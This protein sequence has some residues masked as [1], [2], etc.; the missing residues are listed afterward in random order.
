MSALTPQEKAEIDIH[1]CE[2]K[3]LSDFQRDAKAVFI[4]I[5]IYHNT[6]IVLV[7]AWLLQNNTIATS[8][9]DKG[10]L[11]PLVYVL[12]MMNSMLIIAGFYQLYSFN[13]VAVHFRVLRERLKALVG[14]DVL[15]YEDKFLYTKVLAPYFAPNLE[16]P[17]I[18][19]WCLVPFLASTIIFFKGAELFRVGLPYDWWFRDLSALS[20]LLPIPYVAVILVVLRIT[21]VIRNANSPGKK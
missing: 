14:K 20:S 17:P 4:R 8:L 11:G 13:G 18:L 19:V 5:G 3:A 21:R 15:A 9:N 1:L 2:Y 16:F 10:Y 7:A 6:G 12:Q